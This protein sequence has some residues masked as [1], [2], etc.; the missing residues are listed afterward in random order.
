M[1]FENAPHGAAGEPLPASVYGELARCPIEFV[2]AVLGAYPH[3]AGLIKV[4]RVYPVIAQAVRTIYVVL[5][6]GELASR[7][8]EMMQAVELAAKPQC[9]IAV[10]D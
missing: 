7:R 8:V 1:I 4:N 3:S 10:L 2:Q 5:I 9:S 6:D